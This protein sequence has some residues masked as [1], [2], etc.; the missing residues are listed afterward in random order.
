MASQYEG[1]DPQVAE[2]PKPKKRILPGYTGLTDK[3]WGFVTALLSG[4][5]PWAAYNTVYPARDSAAEGAD[6]RRTNACKLA[7]HPKIKA[8]LEKYR[9]EAALAQARATAQG[10]AQAVALDRDYVIRNL[11][12]VVERC[13]QA[14]PAFDKDGKETGEYRFDSKG[15]NQALALLG[16]EIGM[17]VDRKE[18]RVGP[19]ANASDAELAAELVRLTKELAEATGKTPEQLMADFVR[20]EQAIDVTPKEV[21]PSNVVSLIG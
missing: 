12:E 4:M 21:L 6:W 19:V 14:K 11:K 2:L 13:M 9:A 3:Q 10:M 7:R 5:T 15:A 1:I 8:Y 16:K 18:V 17:F 20:S